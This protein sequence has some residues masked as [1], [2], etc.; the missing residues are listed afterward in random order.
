MRKLSII[1]FRFSASFDCL[2]V[3]FF[4]SAKSLINEMCVFFVSSLRLNVLYC[5][6]ILR[7]RKTR[8]LIK[9]PTNT[10]S[11]NNHLIINYNDYLT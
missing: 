1:I 4:C 10:S 9:L 11:R 8:I 5:I 2:F 6:S 7:L 3:F